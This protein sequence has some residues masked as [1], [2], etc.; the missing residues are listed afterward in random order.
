[1]LS[2]TVNWSR[3]ASTPPVM[4]SSAIA[5][6]Y[7]VPPMTMIVFQGIHRRYAK[8]FLLTVGGA[9]GGGVGGI[10]GCCEFGTIGDAC[11]AY[12]MRGNV[13]NER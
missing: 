11:S 1:V 8:R 2:G 12:R 10:G 6:M 4:A 5:R 3:T 13:L 9:T 7:N